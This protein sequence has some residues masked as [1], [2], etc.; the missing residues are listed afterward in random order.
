MR[1]IF[2]DNEKLYNEKL[3]FAFYYQDGKLNIRVR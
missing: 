1:G 2:V 3:I